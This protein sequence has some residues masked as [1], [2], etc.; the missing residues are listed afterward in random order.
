MDRSPLPSPLP[1]SLFALAA[2]MPVPLLAMG[3]WQGG[4]WVWAGFLY[5]SVLA[6]F[7]DQFVPLVAGNAPEGAEF[8][9][10]DGVLVAVG[11][12]H[13]LLL[14]GAVWAVA[15][16]SGLSP[17][18][19]A[20][21]FLGCG[22]WIGQVAHPAAHELIHR[23]QRGLYRL[24]VAIY[25]TVLIGH[26]ASAHR[27]VHHQHVATPLDPSSA[28][29]GM[30]FWRF[31]PRSWIGSFRTGWAAESARHARRARGRLHPYAIYLGGAAGSIGLG[32]AIA[33]WAGALVWLGIACHVQL[34]MA[35]AD[36]VQHYG[37]RR[38]LRADGRY[39]P[40]ADCHSWNAPQWFSSALMLNAPRH[41]DH[42]AH[43]SRPY[44]ALRLDADAPMLPW[45]LPVAC[46][47]AMLPRLWKRRMAPHVA[48]WT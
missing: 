20:L 1:L 21:V 2:L 9:A 5:M 22:Y 36:Y 40:V 23:G 46:T 16:P 25:T 43:P 15:G 14:P 10:G 27:L 44:P 41:S 30:G 4:I 3:M 13:L 35:L 39:E 45:P 48:R 6:L 33:G 7:L 37:L 28:P 32:A 38:K 34:Q 18:A 11:L 42:H 19:R 29:A 31:A 17:L 8:P 47:L 12:A 24:G 26:H